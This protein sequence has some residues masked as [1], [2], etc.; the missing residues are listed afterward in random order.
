MADLNKTTPVSTPSNR[1]LMPQQSNTQDSPKKSSSSVK[2]DGGGKSEIGSGGGAN[3]TSHSSTSGGTSGG[4][5]VGNATSESREKSTTKSKYLIFH[6]K[7]QNCNLQHKSQSY[8][9][10]RQILISVLK[11][12]LPR[13]DFTRKYSTFFVNIKTEK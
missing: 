13:H 12:L 4:N 8:K 5:A 1:K 7:I 11:L 2:S 10:I 6:V 3:G 9:K